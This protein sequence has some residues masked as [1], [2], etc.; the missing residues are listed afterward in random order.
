MMERRV[1]G[2]HSAEMQPIDWSGYCGDVTSC[3]KHIVQAMRNS[4]LK[5][6]CLMQ[7]YVSVAT[8]GCLMCA[9]HLAV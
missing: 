9:L 4:E 8:H 2:R 6:R 1:L 3:N 7:K 5:S